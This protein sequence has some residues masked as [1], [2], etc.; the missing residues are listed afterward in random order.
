M[1]FDFEEKKERPLWKK[2]TIEVI[3]WIICIGAS[4]YAAYF[5]THYMLEI[6]NM[7]DDSMSQ[8]LSVDDEI[9]INK[10]PY[11]IKDPKRE[12]VIVF[13]A[14]NTSLSYN[15]VK[16]V[17][18]LPGETVKIDDGKIYIDG[19][20]IVEDI[21]VEPMTNGG[22]ASDGITLEDDEYFVLGD[23]RNESEDSRFA[24]IGLIK[25]EDII[26]KAWIRLNSVSIISELNHIQEEE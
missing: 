3:I 13:T 16:R 12:D 25:R 26:G 5:V 22:L 15:N 17:I 9:L 24:T 8:T 20:E 19:E 11:Y 21:N 7:P 4:V 6:T 18:G 10:L 23:N 1:D 2:I 14:S